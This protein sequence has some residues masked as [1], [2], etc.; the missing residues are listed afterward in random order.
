MGRIPQFL[1]GDRTSQAG[2][3]SQETLRN[4][5]D[6]IRQLSLRT[7]WNHRK[8]IRAYVNYNGHQHGDEAEPET[9]VMVCALP[10]GS[11][12]TAVLVVTLAIG[13]RMLRVF[14]SHGISKGN[15]MEN[16]RRSLKA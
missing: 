12:T 13:M 11:L 10:I 3:V 8:V 2:P 7:R 16:G 14:H 9:P 1:A 5:A 15:G 4:A 6:R